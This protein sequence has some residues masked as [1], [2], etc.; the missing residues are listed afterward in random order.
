MDQTLDERRMSSFFERSSQHRRRRRR[1]CVFS[2]RSIVWL[3]ELVVGEDVPF[4]V[5]F[6]VATGGADAAT[7]RARA[8]AAEA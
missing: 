8:A 1:Y 5:V 4:I 2:A 6:V 3:C 7:R